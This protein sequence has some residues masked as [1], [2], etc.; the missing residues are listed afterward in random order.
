MLVRALPDSPFGCQRPTDP[1]LFVRL[2]VL[3]APVLHSLEK[4]RTQI[5]EEVLPIGRHLGYAYAAAGFCALMRSN[6]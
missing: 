3:R 6:S 2:R 4:S 1:V 5:E